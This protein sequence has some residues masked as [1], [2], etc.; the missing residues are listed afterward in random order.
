MAEQIWIA[1]LLNSFLA[2]PA[3]A[4]LRA[5][6]VHVA[7]PA[8]PISNTFAMEILVAG[9]L[10]LGATL[11][12]R[13]LSVD[14][15]GM[16][17]HA[18]EVSWN[19][20]GDH[21]DEVIGHGGGHRFLPYLFTLFF[22]ILICNLI[23]MIPGFESPTADITVTV[24]LALITFFYYHAVGI[25]RHGVF[26]YLKTFAGPILGLAWLMFPLEIFSHFAR[27]L[28]LSVRLYANMYAGE[29]IT[30]IFLAL[31]PVSGFL[32]LGLH[33]FIAL[34]QAYIFLVLA[35]VYL[36]GALAEEH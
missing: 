16:W 24:G 17:Q 27:V 2:A 3:D 29:L 35:M 10:G 34:L 7:H 23:G 12:A 31:V 22:F 20:I 4:I 1:R 26:G 25:H 6:G 9:V 19:G 30:T 13:R 14:R 28:S 11:M 18:L 33:T 32:F 21:G 8:S 36:S 15:P 5:L